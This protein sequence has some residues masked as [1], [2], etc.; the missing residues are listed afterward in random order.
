MKYLEVEGAGRPKADG[1]RRRAQWR[2]EEDQ[3]SYTS[4]CSFRSFEWE[5]EF[6]V[7]S[8]RRSPSPSVLLVVASVRC[9]RL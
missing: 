7:Q 5:I 1:Q 8:G 2:G 4:R 3:S 9:L 6:E